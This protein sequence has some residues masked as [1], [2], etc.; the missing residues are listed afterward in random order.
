MLQWQESRKKLGFLEESQR[1]WDRILPHNLATTRLTSALMYLL[2]QEIHRSSANASSGH[3]TQP[4]DPMHGLA[5]AIDERIYPEMLS[6]RIGPTQPGWTPPLLL[7]QERKQGYVRAARHSTAI[8]SVN[9]SRQFNQSPAASI[10]PARNAQSA[11]RGTLV[12]AAHAPLS[13]PR[14]L[15]R[16][17]GAVRVLVR[18]GLAMP[19]AR[20]PRALRRSGLAF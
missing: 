15:G 19:R 5:A 4:T 14:M 2:R 10:S 11:R 6:K 1:K 17:R 3:P 9:L 8:R 18:C 13:R 7:P 16:A 12:T 20:T